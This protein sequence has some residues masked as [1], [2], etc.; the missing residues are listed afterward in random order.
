MSIQSLGFGAAL[1]VLAA[2][3]LSPF[4]ALAQAGDPAKDFTLEDINPISASYGDQITLSNYDGAIIV[5]LFFTP[6]QD[7]AQ[8]RDILTNLTN[9]LWTTYQSAGCFRFFAIGG[10]ARESRNDIL[11]M[12]PSLPNA[13]FPILYD[14][15]KA[16]W[17]TSTNSL[18][19]SLQQSKVPLAVVIDHDFEIYNWEAG[20]ADYQNYNQKLVTWV[21]ELDPT[22]NEPPTAENFS[23]PDGTTDVALCTA[24]EF[25]LLDPCGVEVFTIGIDRVGDA[26]YVDTTMEP[27]TGGY[28]VTFGPPNGSIGSFGCWTATSPGAVYVYTI[29]CEDRTGNALS[30]DY[31]FSTAAAD[32]TPPVMD[33]TYPSDGQTGVDKDTPI[34]FDIYDDESCIDES[35]MRLYV[36]QQSDASEQE[37]TNSATFDPLEDHEGFHVTYNRPTSYNMDEWVNVRFTARQTCSTQ[38]GFEGELRFTIGQG[39]PS[40][41]NKDPSDGATNVPVGQYTISVDVDDALYGVDPSSIQ[42]SINGESKPASK[43]AIENGYHVW[44]DHGLGDSAKYTVRGKARNMVGKTGET[45]W[46][47]T[48]V[49]N[50]P[51]V[52]TSRRPANNAYNVSVDTDI[53]FKVYDSGVGVNQNSITLSIDGLDVSLGLVKEQDEPGDDGLINCTFTPPSSFAEGQT[54]TLTSNAAD[55]NGNVMATAEWSFA[56]SAVPA[57]VMAGWGNTGIHVSDLG[58]F[59]A[60]ALVEFGE[61]MGMIRNV[62]MYVM[63]A[64]NGKHYPI[65]IFLDYIGSFEGSGV[66]YYHEY[67][68]KAGQVGMLPIYEIAAEDVYGNFSPVWPYLAITDKSRSRSPAIPTQFNPT[69]VPWRVQ[70]LI[71]RCGTTTSDDATGILAASLCSGTAGERSAP[72]VLA[73]SRPVIFAGGFYPPIVDISDTSNVLL[74]ALVI[75]P[76]GQSDLERVEIYVDGMPTGIMMLDDGSQ[77]DDTPGDG[78]Y[79]RTFTLE[80]NSRPVGIV[81]LQIVAFDYAGNVSNVYPYITVEP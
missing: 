44:F 36:Q 60:W 71:D 15:D 17:G 9:G 76:D 74:K 45:S 18:Y 12:R 37:V 25:D 14:P 6:A 75:D 66:Y 38:E 61:G 70:A 63:N 69:D 21:L 58:E 59:E 32:T 49:D 2:L 73:N 34:Y 46:S 35:S 65:G 33:N 10:F 40:F 62:Q 72:L 64:A 19:Q 42:M 27:I 26:P 57:V 79:V 7:A 24:I 50:T 4:S 30:Q 53:F 22:D 77:T 8:Q 39:G 56:C 48:T 23:P 81:M 1:L 55:K 29:T 28:H 54:V 16:A 52:L 78:F 11:G 20:V 47:F 41:V 67:M 43:S 51:P 13:T 80:A 5:L 68:P 31:H 3:L